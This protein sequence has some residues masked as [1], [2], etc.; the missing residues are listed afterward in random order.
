MPLF[1]FMLF[2]VVFKRYASFATKR[3]KSNRS[4]CVRVVLTHTCS[5]VRMDG[6]RSPVL[7]AAHCVQ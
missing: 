1:V 7:M 6:V 2:K 4:H 5:I 3:E